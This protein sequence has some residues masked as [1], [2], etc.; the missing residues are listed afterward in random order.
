MCIRDRPCSRTKA[1]FFSRRIV[2]TK[3]ATLSQAFLLLSMWP[4][5]I[6][7]VMGPISIS[8]LRLPQ[9]TDRTQRKCGG[10][11]RRLSHQRDT[12]GL[13]LF[14]SYTRT[15]SIGARLRKQSTSLGFP[16]LFDT[17]LL[18]STHS[19]RFTNNLA[20]HLA[21]IF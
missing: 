4:V 1:D 18:P 13:P 6:S 8:G 7:G 10:H 2:F 11:R 20:V 14:P 12:T 16:N 21:R 5:M 17:C 19:A 9:T 3:V 15:Q